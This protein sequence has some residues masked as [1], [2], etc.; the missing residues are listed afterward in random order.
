MIIANLGTSTPR[1]SHGHRTSGRWPAAQRGQ[2]PAGTSRAWG[3]PGLD[4]A[5]PR[6][7][8]VERHDNVSGNVTKCQCPVSVTAFRSRSSARG[9]R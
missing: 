2:H 7:P 8:A 4:L 3:H 9:S 1:Q 6:A 5:I